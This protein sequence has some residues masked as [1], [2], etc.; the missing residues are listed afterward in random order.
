MAKHEQR[1]RIDRLKTPPRHDRRAHLEIAQAQRA[2]VM[3]GLV[4]HRR[5]LSDYDMSYAWA[6]ALLSVWLRPELSEKDVPA[7]VRGLAVRSAIGCVQRRRGRAKASPFPE[8]IEKELVAKGEREPLE[9]SAWCEE[10][11]GGLARNQR[12]AVELCVIEGFSVYHASQISG[13]NLGTIYSA[14][15][16][17]L[18]KLRE[19]AGACETASPG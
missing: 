2:E 15:K 1:P 10:M 17:G 7:M 18:D 3:R 14:L 8:G 6:D 13:K 12:L 19:R 16:L 9:Y 11:L 5:G 4:R